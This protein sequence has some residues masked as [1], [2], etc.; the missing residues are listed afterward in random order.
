MRL[1]IGTPAVILLLV[2]AFG[3][4]DQFTTPQP[5]N[6][7]DLQQ[8]TGDDPPCSGD[9][10]YD[11]QLGE[12][13][14]E[15][16]TPND[17]NNVSTPPS[18]DDGYE[19]DADAEECL[20]DHGCE[21]GRVRGRLC[22]PQGLHPGGEITIE[23][24]DCNGDDFEMTT[25]AGLGASYEFDAVPVGTH[26]IAIQADGLATARS[27]VTV[28][29]GETTAFEHEEMCPDIAVFTTG[30]SATIPVF[31]QEDIDHDIIGDVD[32]IATLLGDDDKLFDYDLLVAEHNV[33]WQ[34]VFEQ[35]EPHRAA[36]NIDRYL[37][38]GR[39]LMSTDPNLLD[40]LFDGLFESPARS[41]EAPT[42]VVAQLE[43]QRLQ[44]RVGADTAEVHFD[45]TPASVVEQV[46]SQAEV[47]IR[48]DVPV[49][50]GSVAEQ[51]PLMLYY[52][53]HW[54]DG[55][56]IHTAFGLEH[57]ID[58]IVEVLVTDMLNVPR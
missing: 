36:S 32:E 11:A 40:A 22:S 35:V 5:D 15:D 14:P 58:E 55:R 49:D 4:S 51:A 42:T 24:E 25:T 33:A 17:T 41:I 30:S 26:E 28:S 10:I 39:T 57:Q 43:D 56:V 31:E 53:H 6:D 54:G 19:W 45:D 21:T 46:G 34:E 20:P 29:S 1:R 13:V 38:W 48:A 16:P 7:F 12:C 44:S 18:C 52:D 2:A 3:C 37:G 50:T 23:G 47:T 27:T 9:E 8:P